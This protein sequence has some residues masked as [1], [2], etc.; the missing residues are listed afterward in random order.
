MFIKLS[1]SDVLTHAA[2]HEQ[3]GCFGKLCSQFG[4]VRAGV[5]MH[6][7]FWATMRTQVGVL[8][9]SKTFKA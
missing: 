1:R 8:I 9:A 5:K 3:G 2:G 6:G 7:F 4:V